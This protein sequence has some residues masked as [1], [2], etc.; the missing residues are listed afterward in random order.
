M[1]WAI[2]W[3]AELELMAVSVRVNQY[4]GMRQRSEYGTAVCACDGLIVL[5]SMNRSVG[6]APSHLTVSA[7]AAVALAKVMVQVNSRAPRP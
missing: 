3:N 4:A 7:I 1:P 2:N 5:I 6:L